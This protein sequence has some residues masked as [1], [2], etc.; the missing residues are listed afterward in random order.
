MKRERAWVTAQLSSNYVTWGNSISLNPDFLI[1]EKGIVSHMV[2][3][4][5]KLEI[6]GKAPAILPDIPL[7]FNK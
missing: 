5:I 4:R 2:I 3:V 7:A 1:Y 6:V